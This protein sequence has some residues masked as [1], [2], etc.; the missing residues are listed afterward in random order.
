VG[1]Q[2]DAALTGVRV[3]LV[4]DDPDC[5]DIL[6]TVILA[7]GGQATCV[8]SAAEAVATLEREPFDVLLSDLS[9]PERDGFWLADTVVQKAGTLTNPRVRVMAMTAHAHPEMRQ[10]A[11]EAGFEAVL[12]KPLEPDQLVDA[13]APGSKP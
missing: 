8:S 10:R 9:M 6:C 13:L 7:A 12:I 5:L 1:V 11:V 3:L 2:R 4:D